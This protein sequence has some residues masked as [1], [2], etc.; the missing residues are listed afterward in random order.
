MGPRLRPP[1]VES[2]DFPGNIDGSKRR[3]IDGGQDGA[4]HSSGWLE[5]ADISEEDWQRAERLLIVHAGGRRLLCPTYRHEAQLP[6]PGRQLPRNFELSKLLGSMSALGLAVSSSAS[7]GT[8]S[9]EARSWQCSD[10]SSGSGSGSPSPSNQPRMEGLVDDSPSEEAGLV[11]R[12]VDCGRLEEQE[13]L[14]R[15]PLDASE[16]CG[17][18]LHRFHRHSAG[19]PAISVPD[20][21]Q[22]HFLLQVTLHC[23]EALGSCITSQK[24]PLP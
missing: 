2:N 22:R 21:D 19:R 17:G 18:C 20:F 1:S 23:F 4:A 11:Q 5:K 8:S 14:W 10:S 15:C 24:S 9:P 3:T 7:E 6:P 12:C 13:A 16:V